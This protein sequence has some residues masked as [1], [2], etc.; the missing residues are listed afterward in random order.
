M[1]TNA[2]GLSPSEFT[3]GPGL[4]EC[5][6]SIMCERIVLRC[7]PSTA[8]PAV[9]LTLDAGIRPEGFA[10]AEERGAIAIRGSTCAAVLAGMGQFLRTSRYDAGR[11]APSL[12]RGVSHALK[13]LRGIYFATHFH[14]FFH[15]APLPEV[16]RYVED[17]ALWGFNALHVWFDMHHYT[18]I[19]DPAAQA[20]LERL[21][22]IL[23]AA[24]RIGLQAGIGVLANEAYATSPED[25]RA[26]PN[27]TRAHYRVEL[28]PSKPGAIEQ[29]L[30]WFDE[31]FR[32]FAP[33]SP[34]YLWVWP[35]DQGG[36]ACESC[37]P[38]GAN[39][40]LR[41]ARPVAELFKRH[42]PRGKVILSTWL[43]DYG[44]PQGEWD[45]LAARIGEERAWIDCILA[46]C[47]DLLFP[48]H[49][50]K[51]GVPGG[52]PLLNF[53]E[54]SMRG[55]VPWGGFGANPQPAG[56]QRLW[57]REGALIAGGFPY[58]EGI[59]EDFNKAVMG[60]FYWSGRPAAETAREYVEYE[61]GRAAAD[62]ILQAIAIFEANHA[63]TWE[64][65]DYSPP[66]TRCIMP[67]DRGSRRAVDLVRQ[68]EVAMPAWARTQWRW[69][70]LYLRALIDAELFRSGGRLTDACE[71]WF[72]E[73]TRIYHAQNGDF[74]VRP[75]GTKGNATG[76][77]W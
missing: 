15:D 67:E 43:F 41:I 35:Y 19:D 61:F 27:T 76:E 34:D 12:W 69:R 65:G 13:P 50:L 6:P 77:K 2:R 11:F 18:G 3:V 10:I 48:E 75:P 54:I 7:G 33:V 57:E 45:G 42:F 28:C 20:M 8:M 62:A 52:L 66:Y 17:L 51:H 37:R 58:S 25:L 71:P 30:K 4:P 38:W 63:R 55:M 1:S 5:L 21:R 49:I 60:Q 9:R 32:A 14:N 64:N 44:R 73:L 56:L 26:D 24:K 59:F 40:Y 70:I 36:C 22:R 72:E 74:V 31:E 16:N 68:A 53:P 46:G 39:G 47:H 23:G 29:T